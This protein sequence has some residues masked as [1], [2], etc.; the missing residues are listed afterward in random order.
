MITQNVKQIVTD[1]LG[2]DEEEVTLEARFIEDL[3]ADSLDAVE[4]AMQLESFF[5]VSVEDEELEKM[6]TIGD[7]VGI[8]KTYR[9]EL[10]L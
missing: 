8:I 6:S 4:L 9:P 5:D 10:D 2:V 1:L 7:I 3:A